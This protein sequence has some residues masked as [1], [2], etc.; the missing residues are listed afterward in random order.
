MHRY[1]ADFYYQGSNRKVWR[2]HHHQDQDALRSYVGH[3]WNLQAKIPH[4]QKRK[5]IRIPADDKGL[6]ERNWRERNYTRYQEKPLPTYYVTQEGSKRIQRLD[7]PS[8]GTTNG[9]LKLIEGVYSVT[10]PPLTHLPSR[11]ARWDEKWKNLEIYCSRYFLHDW[12]N[13]ITKFLFFLD[14]APPRKST[15][16]N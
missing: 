16:K 10:F 3:I 12:R 5:T 13:W 7:R 9:Y 4:I 6:Q 15:L 14:Q 1:P 11:N 2:I 8:W